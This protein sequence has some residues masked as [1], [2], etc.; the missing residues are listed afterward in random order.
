MIK[1]LIKIQNYVHVR[2]LGN[3]TCCVANNVVDPLPILNALTWHTGTLPGGDDSPWV[4]K[5]KPTIAVS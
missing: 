4:D 5:H 1:Y 2:A 3:A